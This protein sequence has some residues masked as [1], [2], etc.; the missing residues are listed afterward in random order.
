L[1]KKIL[2]KAFRLFVINFPPDLKIGA[3]QGRLKEIIKWIKLP[4]ASAWG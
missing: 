3:I 1:F 4:R 2:A